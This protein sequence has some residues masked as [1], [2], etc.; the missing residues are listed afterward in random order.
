MPESSNTKESKFLIREL[1]AKLS[2]IESNDYDEELNQL[3]II[4][5]EKLNKR[6]INMDKKDEDFLKGL[7][8]FIKWSFDN[9]KEAGWILSNLTHDICSKVKEEVCFS[10]RTASYVE[11]WDKR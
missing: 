6:R 3:M 10:P 11:Y 5:K 4:L 9:N 8:G 2:V 7:A 1:L